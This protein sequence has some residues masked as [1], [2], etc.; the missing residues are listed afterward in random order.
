MHF[1]F[2]A[3]PAAFFLSAGIT[4]S[5]FAQTKPK[6]KVPADRT[7]ARSIVNQL[8][9]EGR[10]MR[11]SQVKRGMRGVARSVFQGT[12]IEEF[13]I[14]VLGNLERVQGGADI[15][16]IKVLGGPVIKRNS[17]II[18]GMSG[19]PVYI[20][21]KMVGAIAL[22]W[23]FPKEPIGGVTPIESMI[24]S[25]LPDKAGEKTRPKI[26]VPASSG[27]TATAGTFVPRSPL[28]IAGRDIRRVEISRDPRRLA[29]RDGADGATMTLKPVSTLL[30]VSG[31]S[32]SS[33]PRL[34]KMFEP[35]G[36]EPVMGIPSKKTGVKASLAPGAAIGVQLVSGDM[37]QSAVG[38]VT[39]RWGKRVLAFGHPMF[40]QGAVSMP[41]TTSYIHEIFPSY[42]RSFKLASPIDAV[43]AMQ[44][45]TQF[46][47]GGT[48]G[49]RADTIPMT[50]SVREPEREIS[51]TYRVRIM[52]DPLLTPQLIAGVAVEAIETTLGQTSDKMVRVGLSMKIDGAAPIKRRN[53]MYAN[54]GV[55][56]AALFDLGQTLG[57]TQGN[58]FARGS[59]ERVDLS[60]LV[61]P[62]R[63]TARIKSLTADRNKVKAGE[64]VGVR[65]ALELIEKPGTIIT[66]TFQFSVPEDAPSGSLRI[67]AS[68][69]ANFWPLQ[70][71][72]GGPPPEPTTLPQLVDAWAKVGPMNEL[73]VVAST[74]RQYLQVEQ[75]KIKN[76]PPTFSRLLQTA[77][78]SNFGAYN[79]TEERR[80]QTEFML[81]GGQSLD[82]PVESKRHPETAEAAPG[83]PP[84]GQPPA[85]GP[86]TG[87]TPT[88]PGA[89]APNPGSESAILDFSRRFHLVTARGLSA[90]EN[91][92]RLF[93]T[94]QFQEHRKYLAAAGSAGRMQAGKEVLAPTPTPAPD[95]KSGTGPNV[96]PTAE[97]TA[98]P[99]PTATPDPKLLA[100]PALSWVQSP[101][102]FLTGQFERTQV[103][104]A[105]RLQI[106][107]ASR[108]LA[109]TADPFVWATAADAGG[110]T[111]LGMSNPARVVKVSPDGT[112]STLWKSEDVAVT[113]LAL[114][115]NS[116]Y[117]GA[118][119]SGRVQRIIIGTGE[120][121][122]VLA[123]AGTFVG[124]LEFDAQGRLLIGGGGESSKLWRIENPGAE[125]RAQ[126]LAS[127]PQAAIR[128]ISVRGDEIFFGTGGEAVLYRVAG[129][130]V[131][132]ALHQVGERGARNAAELEILGVAAAPEGVYFGA[133]NSGTLWRWTA[134][135][136]EALY[137]SPQQSVF[138]MRRSE[139]GRIYV[140]TGDKGVVYEIRP[141]RTATTTK[142][143]RL[144]E[145]Q[146]TQALALALAPDGDLIVGTGNSGSAY[147]ISVG[148]TS[149]GTFTSTVLDAKTSVRWGALRLSGRGATVETRSGNTL[150]PDATWSDWIATQ[151]DGDEQ[152]VASPAARYLQYRVKLASNG[153]A[154]WEEGAPQVSRLEILYRA[155]NTAPQVTVAGVRGG[156]YWSG[157][158]KVTWSGPRRRG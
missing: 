8:V 110:N 61:E 108:L 96:T 50:V 79:E 77:A 141:G 4:S 55:T 48:I 71:R 154:A 83:A 95:G 56:S 122:Q 129:D 132:S 101:A 26:D 70:M 121:S 38:T 29:L 19:S 78:V 100:R 86:P 93:E 24:Q 97:P 152:R 157:K 6:T 74:P 149:G 151:V 124:A 39:F 104:S 40:G 84:Q 109:K 60:V 30:Q 73:L 88:A 36:V 23:G 119:P 85:G 146:P 138:A 134:D 72:V 123:S 57:L 113:A 58:E 115:G 155:R 128:A 120:A 89:P 116:L 63:Q 76:P 98:A 27:G 43:G 16:L 25:S 33:L 145:P 156:E 44:Q 90:E 5:A 7:E 147:R 111:Y 130:G 153:K 106:A 136:A 31:Y 46:A 54:Q 51:K 41:I 3:L 137:A 114:R 13:P 52:K 118:T 158:Q 144:L 131:L 140:G 105:G 20:N 64:T 82:I 75:Q 69:A 67:A 22:G 87:E 18:A 15:I 53:L 11:S 59:I 66:K 9:R 107:P 45:D 17:G 126:V 133:S 99:T 10:I 117:A 47:I 150:D 102:D 62:T 65:V 34:K 35:Y 42:Q 142:A 2:A 80:E 49:N 32:R 139:D 68:A 127:T 103:S 143:A 125:A 1:R 112:L 135:G 92:V 37:D 21:N 94:S 14:V 81:E 12:K 28:K 148:D 91:Y